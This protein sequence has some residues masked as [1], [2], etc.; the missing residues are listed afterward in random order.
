M[1]LLRVLSISLS[2]PIFYNKLSRHLYDA[3]EMK[4]IEIRIFLTKYIRLLNYLQ[5][6]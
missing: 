2:I 3:I 6:L 4:T 5:L 1:L